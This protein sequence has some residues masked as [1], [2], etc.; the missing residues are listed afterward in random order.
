M[1]RAT[2]LNSPQPRSSA[3]RAKPTAPVGATMRPRMLSSTATPTL[4]GQRRVR[5][6]D[7][8][9]RDATHSHNDMRAKMP[10][11]TPNR[12][13]ASLRRSSFVIAETF[14]AS[15]WRTH[16][17][18]PLLDLLFDG[19]SHLASFGK[20]F[21]MRALKTGRVFEAPVQPSGDAGENGTAFRTGLIAN[22]DDVSKAFPG[23]EHVEHRFGLLARDVD[24]NF[25]HG[26]HDDGVELSRFESCAVRLKELTANLGEQ[27]LRHLAAVTV[28][29][30]NE[31]DAFLFHDAVSG[32]T[33]V[34]QPFS[35]TQRQAN[36]AI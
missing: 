8:S 11:K 2:M 32:C 19:L 33:F 27:R 28:V 12:T 5:G 31:Q 35:R 22:R 24:A 15:H 17:R 21:P 13:I 29:N 9:L 4:L 14:S 16:F 3:N 25:L 1:G 26:F 23:L 10:R 36:T 18:A 30:A 7:R 34:Q 20:L 6:T